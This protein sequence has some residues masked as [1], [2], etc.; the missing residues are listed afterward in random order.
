MQLYK[1]AQQPGSL[2]GFSEQGECIVR[3]FAAAPRDY[4]VYSQAGEDGIIEHIFKCIGPGKKKFVEFGT[5]SGMECESR[6]WVAAVR[7]AAWH[8]LLSP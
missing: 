5:E 3:N 4:T 2:E 6:K 1:W 8:W 7:A